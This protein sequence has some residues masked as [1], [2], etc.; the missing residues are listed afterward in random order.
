MFL[1]PA[2]PMFR[3]KGPTVENMCDRCPFK[4]DGSGYAVNHPD[5]PGI[6]QRVMLGMQFFCH[7]T[8]I[9]SKE[10]KFSYDLETK[11]M[12]PD[13]PFQSHFKNCLGAVLA[14][15]GKLPLPV[16]D[17]QPKPQ[18]KPKKRRTKKKK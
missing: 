8:V 3:P 13:P 14:K 1:P 18:P 6:V 17:E 4:P 15:Q 2:S 10:T 7:E 5:F 12:V 16:L 9:L 11:I